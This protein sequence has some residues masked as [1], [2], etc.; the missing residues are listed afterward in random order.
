[1]L[2]LSFAVLSPELGR[3]IYLMMG[4]AFDGHPPVS[5]DAAYETSVTFAQSKGGDLRLAP[6]LLEETGFADRSAI[7]SNPALRADVSTD[8]WPFFY[9]PQR[10]YP[11]SYVWAVGLIL[12][13]S[14]LLYS[15]FLRRG[16]HRNTLPFF[17][18]GAGFMLVETKGITEL[19][20]A[21]GNT[22]EVTGIVIAA[23]L[24]MAWCG[25]WIASRRSIRR[26]WVPWVILLMCLGVSLAFVRVGGIGSTALARC[27]A[28]LILTS[29]LFFSG[30]VFSTLL[31]RRAEAST[32][33]GVNLLGAMTGGVLEYNS[34][35]FGFQA[36]YWF[37]AALYGAGLLFL[38]FDNS[39]VSLAP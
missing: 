18:L 29:P 38:L 21:F 13:L 5:I 19:G 12:G 11:R 7:L 36:L 23:I 27:T 37:A 26:V 4:E 14:L 33:L 8:D 31:S 35:Y 15:G 20:L 3:K 1:V 16:L 32:A 10:V 25:N 22:W 39:R 24:L 34:M 2:S 17:F 30:I 6:A 9:M 28:V